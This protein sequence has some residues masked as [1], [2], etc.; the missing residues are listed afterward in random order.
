MSSHVYVRYESF[1][2]SLQHCQTHIR[3]PLDVIVITVYFNYIVSLVHQRDLL[4]IDFLS[5]SCRFILLC[6]INLNNGS[7]AF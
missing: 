4:G 3:R 5:R 7:N 1:F 6:R 2:D